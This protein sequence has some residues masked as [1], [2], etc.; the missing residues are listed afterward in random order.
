MRECCRDSILS[1]IGR[2][3]MD[4]RPTVVTGRSRETF[5]AA[6]PGAVT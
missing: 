2:S 6:M 4:E 3:F 5:R 1:E